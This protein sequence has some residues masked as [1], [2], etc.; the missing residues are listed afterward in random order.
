MQQLPWANIVAGVTAAGGAVAAYTLFQAEFG[1]HA[2]LEVKVEEL[3]KDLR[4]VNVQI[5]DLKGDVKR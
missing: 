5:A 3:Q 1:R 2:K 4:D